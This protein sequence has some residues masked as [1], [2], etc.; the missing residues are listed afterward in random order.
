M[1]ELLDW[2]GILGVDFGVVYEAAEGEDKWQNR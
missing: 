2:M 1:D